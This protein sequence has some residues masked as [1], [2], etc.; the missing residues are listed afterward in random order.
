METELQQMFP[1]A[2]LLFCLSWIIRCTKQY[3]IV[4]KIPTKEYD[5]DNEAVSSGGQYKPL[6]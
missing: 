6:L 1:E 3:V 5:G 2:W 4:P